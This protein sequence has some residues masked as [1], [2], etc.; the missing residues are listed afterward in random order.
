[1]MTLPSSAQAGALQEKAPPS[2]ILVEFF[3]VFA[4]GK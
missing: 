3:A 4:Q 1:M 2:A